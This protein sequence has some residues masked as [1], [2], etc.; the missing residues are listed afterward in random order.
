MRRASWAAPC[1]LLGELRG[2]DGIDDL[3][4][5]VR[6]LGTER[7]RPST[8]PGRS[9]RWRCRPE[10][11]DELAVPLLREAGASAGERGAGEIRRHALAELRRRGQPLEPAEDLPRPMSRTDRQ[12]LALVR[13]GLDAHAVAQRLFVTPG[14][15]R[16][17]L[18][19]A[20]GGGTEPAAVPAAGVPAG[21]GNSQ[22]GHATMT[23]HQDGRRP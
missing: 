11:P 10:V 13:A 17:V 7:R 12:I 4:E 1:A 15:V 14:T 22:V 23:H 21:S 19:E 5:A 18:E 20:D 16:A 9:A 3:A 2:P 6:L 8:S